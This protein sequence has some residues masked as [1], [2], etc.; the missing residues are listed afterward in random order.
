[1]SAA[2]LA[3]IND[4]TRTMLGTAQY[5][6]FTQ[7]IQA[8]T[9]T[10]KVVVNEV[11]IQQFYALPYDRWEGYAAER[12]RLLHFLQA[13]TRNVVFLTTDTHANLVN[14]IRYRTLGGPVE[15]S[16]MY[17]A[18]TGPVA[19][20]TFAKEIDG[21]LHSAGAAGFIGSL[22]FKPPPPTGV[23]MSCA[24]FDAYSYAEVTVTSR[25]LTVAPKDA[26]GQPVRE[27]TGA[28]CSPLVVQAR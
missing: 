1:V 15:G 20:N 18:V 28:A 26:Q 5:G 23:G 17:E 7:A 19:T 4:P 6:A 25:T 3:A 10:F 24:A 9:A 8:S 16:E 14:E 2:C 11:P 13:N 22:F 12:E 27:Q 21:F